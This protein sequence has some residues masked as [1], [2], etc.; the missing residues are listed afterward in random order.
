MLD[1]LYLLELLLIYTAVLWLPL[2][3]LRLGLVFFYTEDFEVLLVSG[4]ALSSTMIGG[5]LLLCWRSLET[6]GGPACSLLSLVSVVTQVMIFR[7]LTRLRTSSRPPPPNGREPI[8]EDKLRP[9]G[10]PLY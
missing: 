8:P 10:Y 4:A 7:Y 1:V 2:L 9:L 5:P 3:T 6:L